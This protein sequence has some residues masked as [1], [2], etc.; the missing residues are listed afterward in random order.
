M[1]DSIY[2]DP[3]QQSGRSNGTSPLTRKERE[4]IECQLQHEVQHLDVLLFLY[5]VKVYV[6]DG[7]DRWCNF[8]LRTVCIFV[9]YFKFITFLIITNH[10]EDIALSLCF[11][12]RYAVFIFLHH[13]MSF[14][15]KNFLSLIRDALTQRYRCE[16]LAYVDRPGQT[17]ITSDDVDRPLT[18]KLHYKSSS[19][20]LPHIWIC[21]ILVA[22]ATAARWVS[23]DDTSGCKGGGS[24]S[25]LPHSSWYPFVITAS[26]GTGDSHRSKNEVFVNSILSTILVNVVL[27]IYNFGWIVAGLFFYSFICSIVGQVADSF[28]IA[29]KN[30]LHENDI[31]DGHQAPEMISS[32]TQTPNAKVDDGDDND[33][34]HVVTTRSIE[35]QVDIR[36]GRHSQDSLASP[37]AGETVVT[38]LT[39]LRA[40]REATLEVYQ[41]C[42]HLLSVFPFA[43][44]VLIVADLTWVIIVFDPSTPTVEL[45]EILPRLWLVFLITVTIIY[46]LRVR[47][48]MVRSEDL[49]LKLLKSTSGD[50]RVRVD[51]IRKRKDEGVNG[52]E[53]IPDSL[54]DV[55]TSFKEDIQENPLE[56]PKCLY[57]VPLTIWLLLLTYII[58]IA[59]GLLVRFLE[60]SI[61]L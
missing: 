37:S 41:L 60:S 43:F 27:V 9:L 33:T 44:V 59:L 39:R 46:V 61:S 22:L 45:R 23:F 2:V 14:Y 21:C 30:I 17:G 48:R 52:T 28:Y 24:N 6:H 42:N 15:S 56:R 12:I 5:G 19:H 49:L 11:T 54:A 50:E 4:D 29:G 34:S 55:K 36:E 10:P 20:Y 35:C 25:S 16:R 47:R 31:V 53:T 57:F 58:S 38:S 32:P 18:R 7:I 1:G 3:T 51:I 26:S 8:V 13:W 40:M